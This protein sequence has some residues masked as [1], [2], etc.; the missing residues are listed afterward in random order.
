MKTLLK[1]ICT[2]FISSTLFCNKYRMRFRNWSTV[3]TYSFTDGWGTLKQYVFCTNSY[4]GTQV[5]LVS[6]MKI[7]SKTMVLQLLVGTAVSGV[8]DSMTMQPKSGFAFNQ[9]PTSLTENQF[10]IYGSSPGSLGV[11]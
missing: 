8:L 9:R 11:H 10:M 1:S 6:Y 5:A 2:L 3:S 4:K 7:T